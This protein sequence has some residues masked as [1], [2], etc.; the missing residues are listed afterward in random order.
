MILQELAQ[1]AA[2]DIVIVSQED[3]HSRL[4]HGIRA[5]GASRPQALIG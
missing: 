5:L 3:A 2:H 1:A 4:V